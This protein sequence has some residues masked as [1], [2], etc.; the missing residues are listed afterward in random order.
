MARFIFDLEPV[1]EQR[2]REERDRQVALAAI[3]R[4]RLAIES[5]IRSYEEASRRERL[6]LRERLAEGS[7]RAFAGVRIQAAA[8]VHL[9]RLAQR[10]AIRLAGVHQRLEKARAELL[11]AATRRKA[12]ERLREKRLEAWKAEQNRREIAEVDDLCVMRAGMS[13]GEP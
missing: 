6:E 4:E 5:E 12:V 1:L 7:S 2:R 8:S 11:E 3:E 9:V 13:E 10:A